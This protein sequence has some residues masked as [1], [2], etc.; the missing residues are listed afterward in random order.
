VSSLRDGKYFRQRVA[1]L[2]TSFIPII[3]AR[4]S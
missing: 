1:Q 2:Y 3:A 4:A